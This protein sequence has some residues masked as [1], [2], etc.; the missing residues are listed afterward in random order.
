M[1]KLFA[2]SLCVL[3]LPG[4]KGPA[5]GQPRHEGPAA[6]QSQPAITHVLFVTMDG[7][8]WQELFGGMAPE[9]LTRKEGGVS[10]APRVEKRF[11]G[12]TPE[13]RRGRLMPFFWTTV[14]AKGQ[15]FGDATHGS[16]ARVTNGLRFSY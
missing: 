12:A 7:M 15:V 2:L 14:A 16:L 11:G 13:E 10:D 9:L 6:T 5:Y 4:H 8:R 1:K 3:L